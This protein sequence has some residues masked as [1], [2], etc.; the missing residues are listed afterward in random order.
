MLLQLLQ[1]QSAGLV[2]CVVIF[3]ELALLGGAMCGFRCLLRVRMVRKRHIS[4]NERDLAFVFL[5]DL[6]QCKLGGLAVRTLVVG[7][8]D[9]LDWRIS[10]TANSAVFYADI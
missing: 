4:V 1:F 8:F 2:K 9:D 6:T 3:P 10:R 5:L 7:I